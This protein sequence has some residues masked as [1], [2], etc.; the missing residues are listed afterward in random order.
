L[1]KKEKLGD[2]I[3]SILDKGTDGWGIKVERVEIK[4]VIL[5]MELK[6]AMAKEAEASREKKA[7]LIKA[8]AESESAVLFA[9]AAELCISI[10]NRWFYVNYKPS[11]K[12]ELNKIRLF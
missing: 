8:S 4:D 9:K 6:R 12:L 2:E 10:R 5:P 3:Q 7:R 1:S 11:R